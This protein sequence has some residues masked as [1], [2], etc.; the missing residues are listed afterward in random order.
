M[1]ILISG[2]TIANFN[3]LSLEVVTPFDKHQ[4][5]MEASPTAMGSIWI[6]WRILVKPMTR[7]GIGGYKAKELFYTKDAK[8]DVFCNSQSK[9]HQLVLIEISGLKNYLF[10]TISNNHI[11][12]VWNPLGRLIRESHPISNV[13][14]ITNK[15]MINMM[16]ASIFA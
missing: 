12:V 11:T 14:V 1:V 7:R 8:A 3:D 4:I 2:K 9:N 6:F 15:C 13:T 16:S 5:G 10:I